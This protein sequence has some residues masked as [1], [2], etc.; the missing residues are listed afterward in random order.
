MGHLCKNLSVLMIWWIASPPFSPP[1]LISSS[2]TASR[3]TFSFAWV[4]LYCSYSI[5]LI[6]LI[7]LLLLQPL[8]LALLF[9]LPPVSFPTLPLFSWFYLGEVCLR[10]ST[11]AYSPGPRQ[12]CWGGCQGPLGNWLVVLSWWHTRTVKTW[13]IWIGI[14]RLIQHKQTWGD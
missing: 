13:G 4:N 6:N 11:W 10:S 14:E 9:H 1:L 7:P 12:A 2:H 3:C 5:H 8:V